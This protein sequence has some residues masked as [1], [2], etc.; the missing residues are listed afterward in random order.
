M[1]ERKADAYDWL[2]DHPHIG[3]NRNREDGKNTIYLP[4]DKLSIMPNVNGCGLLNYRKDRVLTKEGMS[5][6]K[7]DLP[8]FFKYCKK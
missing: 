5:R 2:K 4:T 8:S 7:W 1:I 3:D 6:G